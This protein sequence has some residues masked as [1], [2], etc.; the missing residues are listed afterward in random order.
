MRVEDERKIKVT[1]MKIF[2]MI[3][4]KTHK[5][6]KNNEKICEMKGGGKNSY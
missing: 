2:L 3:C 6:K 4:G 5:I 1:E